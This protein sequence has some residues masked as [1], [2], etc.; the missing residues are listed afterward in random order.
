MKS[1]RTLFAGLFRRAAVE[2][3]MAH[4]LRF[5]IDARAA[6]L[7]RRGMSQADAARQARLDFGGVEAYKERCRQARGFRVFDEFGADLRYAF[8]TL[9]HNAGFASMAVL[10]L[11]LGIG[12]N[13]SCFAALYATVL[14]PFP[15]PDLNRIMNVSET[16][17]SSPSQRDPVAPANYIDWKQRTRSFEHLAAF[18]EWDANLTGVDRPDHIHAALASS[19][20]F[21]VL[22]TRPL[23]GRTFTAAE[24]ARGH[25][26]AVVVSY[27]FWRNRLASSPDAIG[28]SVS[29]GSRKYTV[30]GVMPDE[31]ELPLESE[32]WA[33][34]ALT[35][36][37]KTQ[38]GVQQF[39]V[40]GKLKKEVSREQ[41]SADLDGVARQ[42]EQ[43]YP[44][45]N[46]Q[47]R[48]LVT[49]LPEMFNNGTD[50]FMMVLMCSALFVLLLACANVG[51]L[52]VARIISRQKEIGLR[53]ALGA[54]SFRLSRQ[55]FTE[56]LVIGAIAGAFGLVFAAWSLNMLR[57]SIPPLVYRFVCGLRYMRIT[58]EV[59]TWRRP[60]AGCERVV[61]YP[62]RF[63]RP[64]VKSC[65]R[66]ERSP[67][68][69]RSQFE[70]FTVSQ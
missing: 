25:D 66:L 9:R 47:R 59:A 69:R 44:R 34:L 31:F 32:L 55:L 52:Q 33:P 24:C 39:A 2:S 36:E 65:S 26:A 41:A 16:R 13:L 51:S 35:Q 30:I 37:D 6:D 60:V 11:A 12:A 27:A 20:F 1:L 21:D 40:I 57:A 53:S 50:R 56:S 18:R 38:R 54:S 63:P 10:S 4:E 22:G 29:L 19:D 67:Q 46:E 61:L 64:P 5:H 42:L 62:L 17:V 48:V 49:P 58:G 15:F 7:E 28:K 68:G 70:R 14:R 3:D 8:R 43:Q 23:L 45:T